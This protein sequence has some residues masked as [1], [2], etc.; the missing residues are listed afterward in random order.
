MTV[1][2][3]DGFYI[4]TVVNIHQ[5]LPKKRTAISGRRLCLLIHRNIKAMQ[6]IKVYKSDSAAASNHGR[7]PYMEGSARGLSVIHFNSLHGYIL[8]RISGDRLS[9]PL[10][11]S[12][13]I[14][15]RLR[16]P[17][18]AILAFFLHNKYVM[19]SPLN[20]FA[21]MENGDAITEATRAQSVR[22][23]KGGFGANDFIKFRIDLKLCN[24]IQS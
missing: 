22:D 2:I 6:A 15:L 16:H 11:P 24:R 12:L 8:P 18:L 7:R 10:P 14:I 23:V 20:E 1:N 3:H 5:S 4:I 21:F 17:Q 19:L 9:V 13:A